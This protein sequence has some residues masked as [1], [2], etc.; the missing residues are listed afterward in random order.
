MLEIA[1]GGALAIP[2]TYLDQGKRRV[3]TC[4]VSQSGIDPFRCPTVFWRRTRGEEGR[5]K[6]LVLFRR[7]TLPILRASVR[8][9]RWC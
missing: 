1:H 3:E 4:S 9:F 5:N 8:G 7:Q 6:R 2:T